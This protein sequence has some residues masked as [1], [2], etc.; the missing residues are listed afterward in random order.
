MSAPFLNEIDWNRPWL[1][2]LLPVA[3]PILRSLDWKQALN[4]AAIPLRNHRGL[5]IQFVSQAEL[6]PNTSYEAF[7]SDTGRVPTRDNLHD[8]FNALIWLAFPKVKAQ[9]NALQAA[10]IAKA[11]L[12]SADKSLPNPN[13]GKVRDAATIFD[14]NAAFVV[15]NNTGLI[16]ALRNHAWCDL[17]VGRREA[18]LRDCEVC[19]FGHALMEKLVAPYKAITAHAW[20]LEVENI[21][22]LGDSA[23]KLAWIDDFASRGLVRGLS[24]SDFTPLPVLGLPGWCEN[25]GEEF[26][27]DVKVFRPKNKKDDLH[28][29]SNT[30]S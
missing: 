6:P 25:Q 7:I 1:T 30:T 29:P 23:E 2:H 9:L 12:T 27:A 14:E 22:L 8:F 28:S 5:P 19:L 18:F 20:I 10:E 24:T 21:S 16:E 15:M 26:Y 4:T 11:S 13:R 17:F 3:Q